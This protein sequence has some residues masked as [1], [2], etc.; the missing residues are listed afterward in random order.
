MPAPDGDPE[1]PVQWEKWL[2][3]EGECRE[4]VLRGYRSRLGNHVVDGVPV[5]KYANDPMMPGPDGDPECPVQW[6][7]WLSCEGECREG[8]LRGYRSRLG[9]HVVDGVPVG[10]Y[11]NDTAKLKW[12]WAGHVCRMHPDRWARIV[13]EWVPSDGR[14][15]RGRPRR[16]WR[17]DLDRFLPQWPK[18]AH[19][20]ER[21]SIHK[22][23]F[24]QQ[25]DTI[26]AA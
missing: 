16:R 2:S 19:D 4:G 15:R 17:D 18:E 1:C 3:C 20:R 9:N 6:E 24:A 21:W 11:A 12:A 23:A 13:T 8:V 25:W 26:Q 5:G 22:E 10:K 7:K 14:R